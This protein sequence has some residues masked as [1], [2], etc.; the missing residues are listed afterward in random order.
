MKRK[1]LFLLTALM[2]L[3]TGN[4][5]GEASYNKTYKSGVT[6]AAGSDYF[7]YNIGAKQFLTNGKAWGTH[8][9]VDNS[10]R[11]LTLT[12]NGTGYEIYTNYVSLNNR[13]ESKEGNLFANNDGVWVDNG[14]IKDVWFFEPV[15]VDGYTNAYTI[16][17]SNDT[18][19]YFSSVDCDVN[20]G[21]LSEDNKFYW[22][23]IPKD[24]RE[25]AGDYSHY[26]INSQMN[27]PWEWRT[28]CG[29][30]GNNNDYF[31]V[32]GKTD[33]YVGDKA[34]IAYDIF[35]DIKKSVPNGKYKLYAQ[36]SFSSGETDPAP[37]LYA[38][39]DSQSVPLW[40]TND[41]ER[42]LNNA[43]DAYSAGKYTNNVTT[44]VTN[45]TL[46]VGVKM[47][48]ASQWVVFDNFVLEFLG[49]CLGSDAT[50]LT[51]GATMTAGQWYYFDATVAGTYE[52][53]AGSNVS[54]II[55]TT[56]GDKVTEDATGSA[57]TASMALEAT[58]YYFKS[59]SAQTLTIDV[60]TGA[61]VV[62]A[63]INFTND[64]VDGTV[65][66]A[67]NSM[68]LSNTAGSNPF[69]KGYNG[70]N[71]DVLRVGNGT[72]TVTIPAVQFAGTR[73]E[74]ILTF[75]YYFGN[76][77]NRNAGFYLRDASN[78]VIGGLY[79]STY[80]NTEV[81]NSFGV[82]RSMIN[83]IGGSQQQDDKILTA[84]NKTTFEIHLN[85][86]LGTMYLK[87]S[88]NGTLM[89]TTT[90]VT[91]GSKNPL[92]SFAI[93]S[94]YDNDG[95]RC[96]FDNLVINTIK[97]DYSVTDVSYTVKFEDTEGNPVKL[98]DTSRETAE[99]TG[100]SA[101]ATSDDKTTF[102]NDGNIANNS[103]SDFAGATNKYVYKSVSAVNS[104]DEPID[105]LEE[106]AIVTVVYDLYN[107]Y[108]YAVKQKLGD[109]EATNRETG[110]LW[111]DQT[112]TYYFPK[113]VK[114]GNDYY[115]TEANPSSPYFRGTLT[116]AVPTVTINYT[117]DPTVA[118]YSEGEELESKTGTYGHYPDLMANGSCGVLNNGDGN[119]VAN[120]PAGVYTITARVVG[121]G[122]GGRNIIFYKG[123]V[124]D[125]NKVLTT[126]PNFTTGSTETSDP[127][128]LAAATNILVKGAAGGGANGNGLDYVIIHK[129]AE[130][131]T[132]GENGFATF[133]SEYPLD[134]TIENMP[135]GVR[136]F[137]ASITGNTVSFTKLDQTVPANTGVL[138]ASTDAMKGQTVQIP[139]VASGDPVENNRFI[140]GKGEELP[141]DDANYYFALNKN[142][143]N[144][145]FGKFDQTSVV[146]NTNK[147]YFKVAK[148]EFGSGA[149]LVINFD[150][151]TG[152]NTVE[153][154]ESEANAL[155]DGKYLI[156]G[157]I[158]LV[159][160][161]V[162]YGVNGQKLN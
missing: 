58:R 137:T 160:N 68:T 12:A 154:A 57:L 27:C 87:Q 157:K 73:D 138:L 145:T 26:L 47:S 136:A 4:A 115:F 100:I 55:Y 91:M 80:S 62:N 106:D 63:D 151:A 109:G 52:F 142:K 25:N 143:E 18:Y 56:D 49:T 98:D 101:L 114:S 40:N 43:S 24:T 130:V 159:K 161:G 74:I 118:F 67:L 35:Q 139:V 150:G 125:A 84:S 16:K 61:Q 9:S 122:D 66:G 129:T 42:S 13:T 39:D 119:L 113:G 44:I 75:D 36:T 22:L 117:L 31:V 45:N 111:E 64:I 33:N 99:G 77:N 126:T 17:K 141:E 8:A 121:R 78:N 59:S 11:V 135:D 107:K 89:Q 133:A 148:N 132:I 127:I 23:L 162:K 152:I 60:P 10:G 69:V 96:W 19:L 29:S 72:G 15:S 3:T 38:N 54:E 81:T 76:L 83:G 120:L 85:Y 34:W 134:M 65:A 79:F 149:R 51:N 123:S 14:S 105:E 41:G 90:P 20:V 2:L 158:V 32:G 21:S 155:K 46:R 104:S 82:D 94:N 88:T 7:L 1:L 71:T 128:A 156:N 140:A 48:V 37:V 131:A 146:I 70:N 102:Y 124:D 50:A 53:N 153:A 86:A 144:L 30:T 6:V 112:H 147:A 97:G 116:S 92:A 108:D 103:T 93:E 5:W 95:R 28:W 110:T